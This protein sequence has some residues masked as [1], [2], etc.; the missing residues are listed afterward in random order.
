MPKLKLIQKDFAYFTIQ[1]DEDDES[2]NKK[3]FYF[4]E[5]EKTYIPKEFGIT[6]K[7]S[8][9]G[10]IRHDEFTSHELKEAIR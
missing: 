6:G 7:C 5:S 8:C 4:C 2:E 1:F 9:G 3:R 10:K